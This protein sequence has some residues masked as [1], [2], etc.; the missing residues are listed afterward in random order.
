MVIVKDPGLS[1]S[2]GRGHCVGCLSPPRSINGMNVLPTNCQGNLT[3]CCWVTF[4]GQATRPYSRLAIETAISCYR[5]G[6]LADENT[7]PNENR[8]ISN[9]SKTQDGLNAVAL[10]MINSVK[11]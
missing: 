4:D 8:K 5:V 7:L 10:N 11:C 9:S 2:T 1:A 6:H 3:R